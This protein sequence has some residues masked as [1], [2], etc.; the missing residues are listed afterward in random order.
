MPVEP[1]DAKAAFK[2]QHPGHKPPLAR[3]RSC[4]ARIWWGE[5]R[6]G[7]RCPY[8]VT[9]EGYTNTSHF[10]TCPHAQQH[11]KRAP[12]PTRRG[13]ADPDVDDDGRVRIRVRG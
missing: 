9:D 2:A 1:W 12:V 13:A 4:D 11:T 3:C 8:D 6:T 5:T 10:A 7:A